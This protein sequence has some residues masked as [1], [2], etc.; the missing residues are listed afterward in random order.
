MQGFWPFQS[1][2][3]SCSCG[4]G[5]NPCFQPQILSHPWGW[6][7]FPL[8]LSSE[9]CFCRVGALPPILFGV[10]SDVAGMPIS[11]GVEGLIVG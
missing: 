3:L 10:T 1:H 7:H 11:F 8:P 4:W 9:F 2:S 5:C 6:F